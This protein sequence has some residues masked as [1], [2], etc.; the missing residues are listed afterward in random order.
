MR[1]PA[2]ETATDADKASVI[3]TIV[4]AFAADPVTRWCWPDPH[5]YLATM[6]TFALAFGGAAF[7]QGGAH[8]TDDYAGAALWLPP[9]S[10]PDEEALGSLIERTVSPSIRDDLFAVL[11]ADG[12]LSPQR[13]P[14]VSTVDRGGSGTSRPRVRLSAHVVRASAVRP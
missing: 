11:G 6:A 5:E 13:T 3:G 14:L 8:Y 1:V 9:G 2:V 7:A 10:H 12:N 4:L